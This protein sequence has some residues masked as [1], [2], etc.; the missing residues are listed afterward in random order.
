MG[1]RVSSRPSD[2]C[3]CASHRLPIDVLMGVIVMMAVSICVCVS[4]R[5]PILVRMGVIM[6]MAMPI[7]DGVRHR[8]SSLGIGHVTMAVAIADGLRLRL[9]TLG[10]VLV[11]M[12]VLLG[13]SARFSLAGPCIV[14]MRVPVNHVA[15]AVLG[16]SLC[17]SVPKRIICHFGLGLLSN[18]FIHVVAI[19]LHQECC[20]F[21]CWHCF[22]HLDQIL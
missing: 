14:E 7:G 12:A 10:V 8:L 11:L 15:I 13:L 17:L 6:M 4:H 19:Q 9:G 2:T 5:L 18:S 20:A 1:M 3:V 16:H 21:C 22:E